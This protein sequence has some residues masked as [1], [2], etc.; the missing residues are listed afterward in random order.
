MHIFFSLYLFALVGLVKASWWARCWKTTNKQAHSCLS[1]AMNKQFVHSSTVL[2]FSLMNHYFQS[3]FRR[4]AEMFFS[5]RCQYVVIVSIIILLPTLPFSMH[6]YDWILRWEAG[7]L[8]RVTP[9]AVCQFQLDWV[10]HCFNWIT[11]KHHS[12]WPFAEHVV[13][14]RNKTDCLARFHCD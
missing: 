11:T 5:T 14:K 2:L 10:V 13:K 8:M 7:Q 6:S 4:Q 9:S 3:S 12:W 1:M